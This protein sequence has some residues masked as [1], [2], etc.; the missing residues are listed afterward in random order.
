[1]ERLHEGRRRS[2]VWEVRPRFEKSKEKSKTGG[3]CKQNMRSPARGDKEND[4]RMQFEEN[5][6]RSNPERNETS[7]VN[8]WWQEKS[9]IV[10]RLWKKPWN[11]ELSWDVLL[12]SPT[13]GLVHWRLT[14]KFLWTLGTF[15]LAI[16][17]WLAGI[18]VLGL[19]RETRL[20]SNAEEIRVLKEAQ[21]QHVS[22]LETL[23]TQARVLMDDITTAQGNLE[24]FAQKLSADAVETTA[25][26]LGDS[27]DRFALALHHVEER[28]FPHVRNFL[29]LLSVSLPVSLGGEK[30]GG[31][32]ERTRLLGI[33]RRATQRLEDTKTLLRLSDHRGETL[34]QQLL[35]EVESR[36]AIV[37]DLQ[38]RLSSQQEA[39]R[40][41]AYNL[42]DQRVHTQQIASFLES[43]YARYVDILSG[44]IDTAH[45]EV[46]RLESRIS[47][48]GLSSD[49][50]ARLLVPQQ[51]IGGLSDSADLQE[52]LSNLPQP[53]REKIEHLEELSARSEMLFWTADRYRDVL[54]RLPL[55]SPMDS[56]RVSSSYGRRLDP[57]TQ[58]WVMHGGTD[59]TSSSG[60]AVHA[61]SAGEVVFAGWKGAYGNMVEIKHAPRLHTRYAH[62]GKILVRSGQNVD[63]REK[64]GVIGSTGRS[65]GRH[66]HYEVLFDKKPLDPIRFMTAG[67]N[68]YQ[69]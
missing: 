8:E 40:N 52:D 48:T 15:F 33:G 2:F 22:R 23:H 43:S 14:P 24:A 25:R 67:M 27:R 50:V 17:I 9:A 31:E 41:L 68:V 6:N 64:I 54:R 19:F 62:L 38:Q 37:S 65:T 29:S 32:Q 16:V 57:F 46:G 36:H 30:A 26:Q 61:A 3:T 44:M 1:M 59:L 12:R 7:F 35:R 5:G 53:L 18:G 11:E 69:E 10:R 63:A 47:R 58:R 56:Y 20:L 55:R 42:T 60:A 4:K 45:Q 49:Q 13:R 51:S 34:Q 28:S 66:L 21:L 39:T